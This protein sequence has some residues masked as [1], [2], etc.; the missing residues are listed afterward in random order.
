MVEPRSDIVAHD[1]EMVDQCVLSY[2]CLYQMVT[3][4]IG[5]ALSHTYTHILTEQIMG[6]EYMWRK[7]VVVTQM[8]LL[9]TNF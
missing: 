6:C 8:C 5:S 4:K 2:T 7:C 9:R 3:L 1:L